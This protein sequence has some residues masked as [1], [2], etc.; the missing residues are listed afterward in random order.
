MTRDELEAVIRRQ[1]TLAIGGATTSA[2]GHTKATNNATA[3][4]LKAAD[5]YGLA[6]FGIEAER[7]RA[8][9]ADTVGDGS[10][11]GRAS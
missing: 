5:A 9:L 10:Y 11:G 3:A 8:L 6:E 7:R 2:I 1:L 4:I